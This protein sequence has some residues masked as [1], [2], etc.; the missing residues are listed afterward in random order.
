M[1]YLLFLCLKTERG[2]IMIKEIY[3]YLKIPYEVSGC[4]N[5]CN[6][7]KLLYGR[8]LLLEY[9]N[10]YIHASINYLATTFNMSKRSITRFWVVYLKIIL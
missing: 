5:I 6:T 4:K 7:A 1:K 9:K 2:I 3:K 10:G 8:L